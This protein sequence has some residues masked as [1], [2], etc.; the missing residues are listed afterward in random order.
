MPYT[1]HIVC[2]SN[3]MYLDLSMYGEDKCDVERLKRIDGVKVVDL[4]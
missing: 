4:F 2:S 1:S 3:K